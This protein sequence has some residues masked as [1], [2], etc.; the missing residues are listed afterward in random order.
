MINK[1]QIINIFK[2]LLE[3][4]GYRLEDLEFDEGIST[5]TVGYRLEDLE[6]DEGISTRTVGYFMNKHQEQT[7]YFKGIKI[8]ASKEKTLSKKL[9]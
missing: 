4:E 3:T 7:A 9:N 5:R 6:F 1:E 8:K 2:E